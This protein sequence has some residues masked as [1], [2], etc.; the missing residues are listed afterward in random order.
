MGIT[1]D[2]DNSLTSQNPFFGTAFNTNE[3]DLKGQYEFTYDQCKELYSYWGLGKRIVESIIDVSLSVDR[4]VVVGDAPDEVV[5]R[6]KAIENKI[7]LSRI[8][9]DYLC[10]VRVY[11]SA[12]LFVT[13]KDPKDEGKNFTDEQFQYDFK[14]KAL[15]PYNFKA[16][17][18][19][20]PLSLPSFSTALTCI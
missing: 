16:I 8:I 13:S 14:F 1:F 20:N 2:L 11:G 4:D 19:Q 18:S 9:K 6:F 7:N 10:L 15:D 3:D 5:N 12:V 17:I